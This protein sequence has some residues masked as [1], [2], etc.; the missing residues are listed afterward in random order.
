MRFRNTRSLE[1]TQS[2]AMQEHF[3]RL[4]RRCSVQEVRCLPLPRAN[5]RSTRKALCIVQL[6]QRGLWKKVHN[7]A[8]RAFTSP[9]PFFSNESNTKAS[10]ANHEKSVPIHYVISCFCS[11]TAVSLHLQLLLCSWW[12]MV[13]CPVTR[14]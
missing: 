1:T 10:C 12:I 14:Q 13:A 6:L 5:R 7:I 9:T 3:P 8:A 11:D 4:V 2:A